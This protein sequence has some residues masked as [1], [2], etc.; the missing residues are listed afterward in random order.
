MKLQLYYA[1]RACSIVPLI[2]L[3]E[4]GATFDV[5]DVDLRRQQHHADE[6]TRLNPK[7]KV[8]VLL[9]DGRPL[10]ENTAIQIWIDR[11]FPHAGLLPTD[12]WD[13]AQAIAFMS[14]CAS[15]IHPSLT[16]NAHP[17]R[18][19]DL[20][21]SEASVRRLAQGRV[22]EQYEIA[23][24]ALEGQDWF[25]GGFGA[26]DAYF[27]WCFRRGV[28][29]GMDVSAYPLCQAHRA[30]METRASVAQALERETRSIQ[31][32]GWKVS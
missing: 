27:Y 14:W 15:G 12:P 19:C 29:F 7:H 16:P 28:Q 21:D 22:H 30:R 6:F 10:T 5:I 3:A 8:P 26:A 18:Y 2:T 17:H 11:Q 32:L 24:R 25:F 20:P 1:P 4:A 9:I 31:A 23:E 13:Q